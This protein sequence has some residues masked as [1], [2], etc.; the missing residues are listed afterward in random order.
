[1]SEK[2]M[3]QQTQEFFNDNKNQSVPTSKWFDSLY[4]K[5]VPDAK[6]GVKNV[7]SS[8]DK[9]GDALAATIHIKF[10]DSNTDSGAAQKS[11]QPGLWHWSEV[12]PV[13]TILDAGKGTTSAVHHL[14]KLYI[15]S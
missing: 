11:T 13:S 6:D 2:F 5:T 12:K 7:I 10:G 8:T 1:M 9:H 4:P 14:P 15:H 3:N